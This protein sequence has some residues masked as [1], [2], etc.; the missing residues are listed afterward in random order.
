VITWGKVTRKYGGTFAVVS[1]G[2][3]DRAKFDFKEARA[4]I[5]AGL[6]DHGKTLNDLGLG[7]GLHQHTSS[8]VD[9]RDEVYAVMEA[10]DTR[11]WFGEPSS[12]TITFAS[13]WALSTASRMAV[14]GVRR[15]ESA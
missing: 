9:T 5:I 12:S 11:Y 1:A 15:G 10:V 7:A 8:A 2:G 13:G 3:V 4:R 6:N 14:R